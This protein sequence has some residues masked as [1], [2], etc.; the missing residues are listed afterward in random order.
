MFTLVAPPRRRRQ[1]VLVHPEAAATRDVTKHRVLGQL[2]YH[3]SEKSYLKY[4]QNT[5]IK[6]FSCFMIF[7]NILIFT[8]GDDEIF[9]FL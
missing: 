5:K 9:E 3:L 8:P 2:E 6:N 7:I 1:H 4:Y